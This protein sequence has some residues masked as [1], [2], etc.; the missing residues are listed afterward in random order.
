MKKKYLISYI[1]KFGNLY[2]MEAIQSINTLY[3]DF[4][5]LIIDEEPVL[6]DIIELIINKYNKLNLNSDNIVILATSLINVRK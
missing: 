2:K 4:D 5:Y 1:I 3:K 6:E